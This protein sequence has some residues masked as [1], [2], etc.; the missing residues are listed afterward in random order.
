MGVSA[1]HSWRFSVINVPRSALASFLVV[2]LL[3]MGSEWLYV[4][5]QAWCIIQVVGPHKLSPSNTG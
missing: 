1:H 4:I 2:L 3:T 5:A